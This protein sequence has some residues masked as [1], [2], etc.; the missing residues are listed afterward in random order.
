MSTQDYGAGQQDDQSSID[1]EVQGG[2]QITS[3][4]ERQ[5]GQH[6]DDHNNQSMLSDQE[7][8]QEAMGVEEPGMQQQGD[9]VTP[10]QGSGELVDST[11][12]HMDQETPDSVPADQ[13]EREVVPVTLD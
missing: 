11:S 7:S 2:E 9:V 13:S 5:G 1:Q 8:P 4:E 6:E 3:Q 12:D 10:S